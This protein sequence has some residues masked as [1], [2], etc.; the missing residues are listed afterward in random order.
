MDERK[1]N[2]SEEI[3]E[4]ASVNEDVLTGTKIDGVVATIEDLH[5]TSTKSVYNAMSRALDKG[6]P[7]D[8]APIEPGEE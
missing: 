8:V 6:T 3:L 1:D 2:L 7:I 4:S 5:L